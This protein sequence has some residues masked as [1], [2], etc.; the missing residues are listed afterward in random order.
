MAK[1]QVTVGTNMGRETVIVDTNDTLAHAFEEADL[2]P[3][4]GVVQL[5]GGPVG[6][7]GLAKTF[8]DFDY[9]GDVPAT[10][11]SVVKADNA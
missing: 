8:A 2:K 4:N 3:G 7:G 10:L 11:F 5:D 6:A 1:I 9:T